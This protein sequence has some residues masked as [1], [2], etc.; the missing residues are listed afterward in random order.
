M[1]LICFLFSGLQSLE[2]HSCPFKVEPVSP[3]KVTVEQNM[4]YSRNRVIGVIVQQTNV[5]PEPSMLSTSPHGDYSAAK[6]VTSKRNN[7][8]GEDLSAE[9]EIYKDSSEQDTYSRRN[10]IRSVNIKCIHDGY[11]YYNSTDVTIQHHSGT[12]THIELSEPLDLS[13]TQLQHHTNAECV[14]DRNELHSCPKFR[15]QHNTLD[16]SMSHKVMDDKMALGSHTDLTETQSDV[17]CN[18]EHMTSELLPGRCRHAS[19]NEK[20]NSNLNNLTERNPHA[21][22]PL[23]LSMKSAA[24]SV[25][26]NKDKCTQSVVTELDKPVCKNG[27][28]QPRKRKRNSAFYESNLTIEHP[29][30]QHHDKNIEDSIPPSQLSAEHYEESQTCQMG[31]QNKFT[32]VTAGTL[33]KSGYSSKSFTVKKTRKAHQQIRSKYAKSASSN[34]KNT[35]HT[36]VETD[37]VTT[38][39]KL[40]VHQCDTCKKVFSTGSSLTQHKRTHT[41]EK[42][43]I[44]DE[45]GKANTYIGSLKTHMIEHTGD[46]YACKLCGYCST[47]KHDLTKH[48]KLH[49]GGKPYVCSVCGYSSAYLSKLKVHERIHT[50]EKPYVCSVCGY[51]SS[52]SSNLNVHKRIHTGEKPYVCKVC[53]YACAELS[54]L[55]KHERVHT[56]EKPYVCKVC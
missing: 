11:E 48:E 21:D 9:C 27:V 33:N 14:Q 43:Y 28:S 44:C 23:D 26:L 46:K 16:F 45:G 17:H 4:E 41:G 51:A 50:G 2:Y 31:F 53:G 18:L 8:H 34:K 54:S 47:R 19:H 13:M 42:P 7:M 56:G 35:N 15:F 52:H 37:Y 12:D 25:K 1:T 6:S 20:S 22:I 10:D 24:I 38:N 3:E 40:L 32:E 30:T 55:Q 49:T 39:E 29:I 5:K 36:T